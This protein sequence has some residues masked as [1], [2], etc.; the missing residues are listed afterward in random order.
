MYKVYKTVLGD[1]FLSLA[2]KLG[3]SSDELIRINGFSSFDVGDLIVVPNSGMFFTY[4]VKLGDSMYSIA[5][6]YN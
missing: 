6:E 2:S 1:T 3:I 5:Q 4:I